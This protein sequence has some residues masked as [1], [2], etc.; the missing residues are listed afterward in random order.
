MVSLQVLLDAVP[1]GLLRLVDNRI[2]LGD[3]TWIGIPV[4]VC[5]LHPKH[6]RDENRLLITALLDIV[7]ALRQEGVTTS[8]SA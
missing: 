7:N 3:S 1:H 8:I 5:V 2:L 6:T 4:T